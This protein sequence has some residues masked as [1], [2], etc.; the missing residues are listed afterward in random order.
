MPE[1]HGRCISNVPGS[2]LQLFGGEGLR[3]LPFEVWDGER[4]PRR[5]ALVVLDA[6]GWE[7]FQNA[8]PEVPALGRVAERGRVERLTSVFPSTTNVALT[9]LYTGLTPAEH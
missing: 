9:S 1:Y 4:P 3:R 6:L 2:I 5:V 8:I 7:L